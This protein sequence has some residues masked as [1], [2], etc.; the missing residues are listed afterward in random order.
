MAQAPL[1]RIGDTLIVTAQEAISDTGV[2]E[3]EDQIAEAI[4][5]A[6]ASG[7]IID[8]TVLDI[9][10]SFLGRMLNDIAATARLMGARTVLVGIQPAVAITLTELGLQLK[11]IRTALNVAQALRLLDRAG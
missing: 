8:I 10:D 7:L 1:I 3:L 4:E 5:R 9:V 11:G 2:I 6:G